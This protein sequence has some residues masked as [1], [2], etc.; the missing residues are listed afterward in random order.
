MDQPTDPPSPQE[1]PSQQEEAPINGEVPAEGAEE[2]SSTASAKGSSGGSPFVAEP[3]PGF[4][5]AAAPPGPEPGAGDGASLH[6]LPNLDL[7]W[8][9]D[10]VRTLLTAQGEL[11]HGAIGLA[12]QDWCHTKADLAA[13]AARITRRSRRLRMP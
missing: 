5:P 1:E 8:D 10:V 6:A 7:E 13:I 9:E 3:G 12:E 11:T 2:A 4:D